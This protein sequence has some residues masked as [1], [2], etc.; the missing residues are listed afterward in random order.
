MTNMTNISEVMCHFPKYGHLLMI[1][2][3]SLLSFRDWN[4]TFRSLWTGLCSGGVWS[5]HQLF[6]T[7]CQRQSQ[8]CHQTRARKMSSLWCPMDSMDVRWVDVRCMMGNWISSEMKYAGT[9]SFRYMSGYGFVILIGGSHERLLWTG[10]IWRYCRKNRNQ[11]NKE[12][13]FVHT[14]ELCDH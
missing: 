8:I 11:P 5:H 2:D 12:T 1:K 3:K 9:G 6:R 13:N 14:E 4:C 10:W 7:G